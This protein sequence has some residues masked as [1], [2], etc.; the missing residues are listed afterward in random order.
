MLAKQ[1][2]FGGVAL[3]INPM[4]IS[5]AQL[6]AGKNTGALSRSHSLTEPFFHDRRTDLEG[7]LVRRVAVL[8]NRLDALLTEDQTG[9]AA[10]QLYQRHIKHR[11]HL[12]V[13]L[14]VPPTNNACESAL[15]PSVIHRRVT[16]GFR[17][18]RGRTRLCRSRYRTRNRQTPRTKLIRH[19]R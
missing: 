5:D 8:E 9:T 12:L 2:N 1:V 15:R 17:S 11:D 16:N 3:A 10:Q 18:E 4:V 6:V 7:V 19:P 13:F 14:Q